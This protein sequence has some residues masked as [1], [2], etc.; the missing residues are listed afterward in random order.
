MLLAV[1]LGAVIGFDRKWLDRPAGLR[2]YMLTALAAA[3]FAVITLE[4]HGDAVPEGVARTAPIRVIEAVTV[5]GWLFLLPVSLPA[6]S[7]GRAG[8]KV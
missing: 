6:R 3:L 7:S 1:A 4:L 8:T 2:T 5:A